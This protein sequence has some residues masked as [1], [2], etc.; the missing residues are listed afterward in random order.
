MLLNPSKGVRS[1][2]DTPTHRG[3]SDSPFLFPR[4]FHVNPR[5]VSPFC[6]C[7]SNDPQRLIACL[8]KHNRLE[9]IVQFYIIYINQL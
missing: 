9:T 2:A 1:D 3:Q 5:N 7:K 8:R 6:P 4:Y